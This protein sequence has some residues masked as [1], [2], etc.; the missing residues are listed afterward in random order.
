M[1]MVASKA[2]NLDDM[3]VCPV[4]EPD[5]DH[6]NESIKV[7]SAES[8]MIDMVCS[9]EDPKNRSVNLIDFER[10]HQGNGEEI[11][12]EDKLKLLLGKYSVV[13]LWHSYL[14]YV[15]VLSASIN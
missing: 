14:F 2:T 8:S 1:E 15:N 7:C 9:P 6:L 3:E 13:I 5:V 10:S 12:A 11:S 4:V